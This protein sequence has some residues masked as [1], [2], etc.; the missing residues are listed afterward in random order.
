MIRTVN[1]GF[2][3]F[4]S[5]LTPTETERT[6]GKNHRA[7][8]RAALEANLPVIRMFESGSFSHGTGVRGYSD[9]DAFVSLRGGR[10]SLSFDAL[11]RVAN[12]LAARFPFTR[13]AI[14]RPAVVVG[15]GGG[16]ETWEII[17]AFITGLGAP[18]QLVYE[19]PGHGVGSGWILSAPEL[20]LAYVNRCNEVPSHGK[21][22]ALAR[23]IKAWK[24]FNAV[25]VS[26]FYL[27]MRCAQL[28]ASVRSY[29]HI[30]DVWYV[31][32]M[33]QIDSLAAMADPTGLTGY[34][35]A[36]STEAEAR[37]ALSKL[38]SAVGRA[39]NA[40]DARS[41]S[42]DER[43]FYYLSILFGGRFPARIY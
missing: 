19:I 14:Q 42:N 36:C 2:R 8:V 31:L 35:Y 27:E 28:V 20:H 5:R 10:P 30:V 32:R 37:E 17:P 40:L 33:M 24:Y 34:F 29:S 38:D 41:A 39:A 43:A 25:P 6:A 22:K 9:I 3:E 11:T 7:S 21:A 1:E 16:Y 12:V 13:V 18:G 26:S 4:L 15:F 23:L